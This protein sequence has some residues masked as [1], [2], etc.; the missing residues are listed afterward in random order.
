MSKKQKLEMEAGVKYRGYGFINEFGEFEFTPEATG[1][2]Q[3]NVKILKTGENFTVSYSSKSLIFHGRLERNLPLLD[4][5][6]K[7]TQMF[8]VIFNVIKEYEI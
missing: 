7:L 8:N 6:R 4:R 5:I 3:G 1:S 2:R